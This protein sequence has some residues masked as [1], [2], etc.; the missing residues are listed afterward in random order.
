LV[1]CSDD[2][3]SRSRSPRSQAS[4][5]G[6]G[7]SSRRSA[8]RD[9]TSAEIDR[10]STGEDSNAVAIVGTRKKRVTRSTSTAEHLVGVESR[11]HHMHPPRP[12]R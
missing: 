10:S 7:D 5:L 1:S 12:V 4:L 9:L 3:V 8:D 6:Q 11:Q 2:S